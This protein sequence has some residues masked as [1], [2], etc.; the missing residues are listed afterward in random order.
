[1]SWEDAYDRAVFF[2]VSNE[3]MNTSPDH[4]QP[5]QDVPD[6][7]K[8]LLGLSSDCTREEL[9]N[10]WANCVVPLLN[11]GPIHL[12]EREAM[13]LTGAGLTGEQ[14][15]RVYKQTTRG[16]KLFAAAEREGQIRARAA[17]ATPA[18]LKSKPNSPTLP[19]K[20]K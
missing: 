5:P 11:R 18:F 8:F 9:A 7:L 3:S 4:S 14:A 2:T 12:A 15:R 20:K 17:A 6:Y 16:K 13:H 1:M 19:N 10:E